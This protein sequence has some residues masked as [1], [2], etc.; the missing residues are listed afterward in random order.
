VAF[1]GSSRLTDYLPV[2]LDVHS[3]LL[4]SDIAEWMTEHEMSAICIADL[5]PSSPSRTRYLVKRLRKAAPDLIIMVGRWG[6]TTND[7]V[8]ELMAAGANHVATTFQQSR[9]FLTDP[10]TTHRLP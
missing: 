3:K 7:D 8:V 2:T 10:S 5:P 1:W 6:A 9:I 4:S